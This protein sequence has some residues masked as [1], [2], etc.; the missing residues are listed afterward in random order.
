VK[1]LLAILQVL[2]LVAVRAHVVSA[3][4]SSV[5]AV[6]MSVSDMDRAVAFYSELSFQKVSDIEVFGDE[7]ESLVGVFGARMR[8]V[9]MQL[10]TELI[11]LTEY[12]TPRGKP[13]PTDSRSNDLWF[14]HIAIV[15]SDMTKAFE[16]LRM[17]KVQLVS[18]A[19]Q[20]LPDWNMAAA[21]IEAFYFQDPDRHNLEVIYFPPG[22][23][24][25]RW[26]ER[27]DKLFLGLDHTAI[28]V[29]NTEASLRFYR[30]LLGF[31]KAGESENYGTEQEHLNQVFGAYLRITG[32]R[33]ESGPGIEFLEYLSPRDGRPYPPE[34]KPNDILYWNTVLVTPDV[35]GLV[36]KLSD[37]RTHFISSK[38]VVM[39]K[40]ETGFS[41]G[42][43]IADPD[44]HGLLLT[45]K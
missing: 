21:G 35:D 11:E 8:I 1:H 18:T 42:I 23:G 33:A 41:K 10:G 38:V 43:V 40:D 14:Q 15:V 16:K 36:S 3:E 19:P 12:L 22:K 20:R 13:I 17:L 44:G 29:S 37:Q 45:Q 27:T 5:A 6:G 34:N 7:Y 2:L 4:V 9:R 24:N 28:A 30:D 26:Q 32:M 25:P 31:R 39:P